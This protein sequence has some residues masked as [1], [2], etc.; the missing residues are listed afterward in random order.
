MRWISKYFI[1]K[2]KETKIT[3]FIFLLQANDTRSL[4]LKKQIVYQ[5]MFLIFL[6]T[7]ILLVAR[8]NLIRNI[9]LC[10]KHVKR[11]GV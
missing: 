6:D 9:F 8:G 3:S 4:F 11:T 10:V 2:E 1:L 5:K 7:V